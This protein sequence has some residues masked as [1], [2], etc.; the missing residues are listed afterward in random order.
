[1]CSY[2][3]NT[4][5][6]NTKPYHRNLLNEDDDIPLI[7]NHLTIGTKASMQKSDNHMQV[8]ISNAEASTLLQINICN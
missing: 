5:G 3:N 7:M 6:T 2:K 1:M 8:C 4:N